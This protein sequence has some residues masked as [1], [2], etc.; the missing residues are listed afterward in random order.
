M[1]MLNYERKQYIEELLKIKD[2]LEIIDFLRNGLYHEYPIAF[3]EEIEERI[4]ITKNKI[5]YQSKELYNFDIRWYTLRALKREMATKLDIRS[6]CINLKQL[7]VILFFEHLL[8]DLD[9]NKDNNVEKN[10]KIKESKDVYSF[11]KG[12]IMNG[13]CNLNKFQKAINILGLIKLTQD[14]FDNDM[15]H[16]MHDFIENFTLDN[17]LLPFINEYKDYL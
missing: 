1:L 5:E 16:S 8:D 2:K 9:N 11:F 4:K 13:I 17:Y 3:D 15:H 14:D 6:D 10:K 7:K 12:L